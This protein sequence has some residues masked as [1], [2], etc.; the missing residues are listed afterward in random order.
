MTNGSALFSLRREDAR[1]AAWLTGLLDEE[2]LGEMAHP[3]WRSQGG[4][5]HSVLARLTAV[6]AVAS[7]WQSRNSGRI[8][9]DAKV[10]ARSKGASGSSENG[11]R[12]LNTL[13]LSGIRHPGSCRILVA[14][15]SY[16]GMCVGGS[17]N[18]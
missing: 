10:V 5:H 2:S 1:R 14:G 6:Q 12:L 18:C 17:V 7:I 4:L 9:I 16:V 11:N 8:V 13:A 15:K 3:G